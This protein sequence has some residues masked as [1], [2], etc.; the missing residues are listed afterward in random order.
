MPR[1]AKE[2][3][4]IK[5]CQKS[6]IHLRETGSPYF[7]EAYFIVK[8]GSDIDA[9]GDDIIKEAANIV[10]NSDRDARGRDLAKKKAVRTWLM[11]GASA[12]SFIFGLIMLVYTLLSA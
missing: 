11:K 1:K 8:R 4:M 12:A 7:E 5:G 9:L 6:I 10:K 3:G 2:S